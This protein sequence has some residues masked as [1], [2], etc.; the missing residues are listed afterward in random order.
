MG[1]TTQPCY[2]KS[3]IQ[4]GM[5][6]GTAL[7]RGGQSRDQH[8]WVHRFLEPVKSFI[9]FVI[10]SHISGGKVQN[11]LHIFLHKTVSKFLHGLLLFPRLPRPTE[12]KK[13]KILCDWVHTSVGRS[14]LEN[15]SEPRRNF[16]IV[17]CR[18]I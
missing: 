6:K 2:I 15:C 9:T 16:Y 12:E 3:A 18:K 4:L 7:H 8:A 11:P 17:L 1:V 5:F 14:N 10:L 13:R